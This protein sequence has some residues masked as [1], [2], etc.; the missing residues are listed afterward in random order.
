MSNLHALN[1]MNVLLSEDSEAPICVICQ[2][3]LNKHQTYKLPE[4]NHEFHTHCIVT[5]FRHHGLSDI[6]ED[7][8]CPCCGNNGINNL[9]NKRHPPRRWCRGTEGEKYKFNFIMREAKKPDAPKELKKLL[10]KYNKKKNE[11]DLCIQK[12]NDLT[13]SLKNELVNYS[14]TKSAIGKARTNIWNARRTFYELKR[15]ITHF[16]IIPL[17]IPTPIDINS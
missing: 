6:Q 11:F 17:I 12:K 13:Q 15:V 1:P 2:D 9:S 16:P 4:C 5:W 10:E 14:K 7:G 8:R 3:V